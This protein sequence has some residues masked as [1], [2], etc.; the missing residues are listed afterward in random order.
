M[1]TDAEN[2]RIDVACRD[3]ASSHTSKTM[4]KMEAI[5]QLGC[6]ALSLSGGCH[7]VTATSWENGKGSL[8]MMVEQYTN[9]A[10]P[11]IFPGRSCRE[12]LPVKEINAFPVERGP[13][14][15]QRRARARVAGGTGGPP[16]PHVPYVP[17]GGEQ[18]THGQVAL[19]CAWTS[20]CTH[21]PPPPL[22]YR[23]RRLAGMYGPIDC[24]VRSYAPYSISVHPRRVRGGRGARHGASG[25]AHGTAL[26]TAAAAGGPPGSSAPRPA[27]LRKPR[28]VGMGGASGWVP[29]PPPPA[30][31]PAR[32]HWDPGWSPPPPQQPPHT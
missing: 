18:S 7:G 29:P 20:V 11:V 28:A 31:T 27:S 17:V 8:P 9:G 32:R 13:S 26:A 22:L 1:D 6:G 30:P 5:A 14:S 10:F 15:L 12:A 21:P 23:W 16:P 4:A 3:V 25:G 19:A 24:A 2:D